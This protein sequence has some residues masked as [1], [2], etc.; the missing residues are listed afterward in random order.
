MTRTQSTIALFSLVFSLAAGAQGP[1]KEHKELECMIGSWKVAG[2]L[3][4]GKDAMRVAGSWDCKSISGGYGVGCTLHLTG[5]NGFEV[6]EQDL[7]SYDAGDGMYHWFSVT[8]MGEVHDHK[9]NLQ[10]DNKAY[11][12]FSGPAG[13][14]MLSEQIQFEFSGAN[15]M[16][17]ISKTL[18]GG[19]QVAVIDATGTK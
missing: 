13:G 1:G 15:K 12:Q 17:I 3:T 6:K 8:N 16:R 10:G 4:Q 14:E 18:V 5:P 7:L 9:G 2:T 19:Q 11:F